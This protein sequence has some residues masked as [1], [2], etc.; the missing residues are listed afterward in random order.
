LLLIT[1]FL[2]RRGWNVVFLGAVVP[3]EHMEETINAVNPRLLILSA[4]TLITA[5]SLRE[6]VHLLQERNMQV[7]F[8]GRVF[9]HISGLS[10]R[11]PAHFLGNTIESAIPMIESLITHSIP[12]PAKETI[13]KRT[14]H[15]AT[16]YKEKRFMIESRLLDT[17]KSH[18]Q[19]VDY[20]DT[21][22]HFLGDTLT[23]ALDLGDISYTSTDIHWLTNLLMERNVSLSLLPMFLSLY[24]QASREVMGEDGQLISEWL[25]MEAQK[26]K[27]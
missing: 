15:L 4:Q 22:I 16:A 7:A 8:G 10:G 14:L 27:V 25:T 26:L 13:E 24:A 12:A 2:R 20:I 19:S 3:T 11:I 1:L 18:N 21:A 6:M 5:L 17:L 23:A 9:N